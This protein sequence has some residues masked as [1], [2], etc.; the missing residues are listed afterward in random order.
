MKNFS[1]QSKN[2]SNKF[3]VCTRWQRWQKD[4]AVFDNG[5]RYLEC[6][7]ESLKYS[8]KRNKLLKHEWCLLVI[9]DLTLVSYEFASLQNSITFAI[10]S[11]FCY[12][13]I[14]E[15]G[16]FKA[17]AFSKH[18]FKQYCDRDLLSQCFKYSSK[19]V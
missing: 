10:A 7:H 4:D 17:T 13:W 15:Q 8:V 3:F 1:C 5:E 9:E 2:W 11:H 16:D 6:Y 14:A 18:W 19:K 12:T